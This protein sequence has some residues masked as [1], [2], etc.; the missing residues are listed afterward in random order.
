MT[1]GLTINTMREPIV[2][3]DVLHRYRPPD[4]IVRIADQRT[5]RIEFSGPNR[6]PTLL[7]VARP[8][9][10]YNGNMCMNICSCGCASITADSTRTLA[11]GFDG[12]GRG[13]K[14]P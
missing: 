5:M 3:D 13:C 1:G 8:E 14:E 2:G 7:A 12:P 9:E 11:P 6:Q 10:P 4:Q